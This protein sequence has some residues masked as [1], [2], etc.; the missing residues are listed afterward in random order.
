M[1]RSL[2][3]I[4]SVCISCYPKPGARSKCRKQQ[5]PTR[6]LCTTLYQFS[7]ATSQ[8][9]VEALIQRSGATSRHHLALGVG[10]CNLEPG[11]TLEM[12]TRGPPKKK[13]FLNVTVWGFCHA[14]RKEL[15]LCLESININWK[16]N[17]DNTLSVPP[18]CQVKP[19]SARI[20]M[21]AVD[22]PDKMQLA[23]LFLRTA[24]EMGHNKSGDNCPI[25]HHT[26]NPRISKAFSSF[27]SCQP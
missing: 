21:L 25:T 22:C 8:P 9:Q 26:P 6:I 1:S 19:S 18:V 7:A 3:R 12:G 14:K 13:R 17:I 4:E 23:L 16:L 5:M 27:V 10:T 24:T 20:G 11:G 2:K 15:G